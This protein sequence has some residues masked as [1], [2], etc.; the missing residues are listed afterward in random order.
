MLWS[1][2]C[3]IVSILIVYFSYFIISYLCISLGINELYS[4]PT[5][6]TCAFLFIVLLS[7]SCHIAAVLLD[8]G[9]ITSETSPLAL[10]GVPCGACD[11]V[12]PPR[13]HHCTTCGKCI[14]NMDH[15][16][17]W[18]NNCVGLRNQKHF[19]LFLVYSLIASM[20]FLATMAHRVLACS[21]LD[22]FG[23]DRP[24][25]PILIMFSSFFCFFYMFLM[26]V[27]LQE[28]VRVVRTNISQIDVMQLRRF[29]KVRVR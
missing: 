5:L 21:G 27:T 29:Q 28:Q 23:E 7:A 4:D 12:K 25:D 6:M 26:I 11:C 17:P 13:A 2:T 14:L 1:D 19:I 10:E 16:C 9:T 22:C 24:F 8:P 18:I 20:W 3:G 15:H